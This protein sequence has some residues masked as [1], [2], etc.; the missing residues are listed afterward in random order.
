KPG[1]ARDPLVRGLRES[2]RT[3]IF[4]EQAGTGSF[5]RLGEVGISFDTTG[6]MSF[7]ADRLTEALE[8]SAADVT[9]LFADRFGAIGTL[10]GTYTDAGG[11][12]PD[13]RKR[14]DAQ[15]ASLGARIDTLEDQ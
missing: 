12:V 8:Q 6:K 2:L 7:D 5:A 11:L 3:T 9:A 13:I 4:S 14:L 15:V 10:V 1:I